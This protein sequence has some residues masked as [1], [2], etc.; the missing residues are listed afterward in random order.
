MF[1]G[2]SGARIPLEAP[3][4]LVLTSRDASILIFWTDP[5]DKYTTPGG[6]LVSEWAYSV[7]VRK[8]GSAPTSPYD[9]VEVVRTTTRN[10]Y[11]VDPYTDSGL[12]NEVTYYYAVYS[13]TTM[14]V[15][16][17]ALVGNETPTDATPEYW[18]SMDIAA[19]GDSEYVYFMSATNTDHHV[20]IAGGRNT[21]SS[22]SVTSKTIAFNSDLVE[23]NLDRDIAHYAMGARYFN[24]YACF[25]CGEDHWYDPDNYVYTFDSELTFQSHSGLA[26]YSR[27][28]VGTARSANHFF[29]FGGEDGNTGDKRNVVCFDEDFTQQDLGTLP[30]SSDGGPWTS[31]AIAGGQ[32]ALLGPGDTSFS[33]PSTNVYSYSDELV[34]TK[35]DF[36]TDM[37]GPMAATVGSYGIFAGASGTMNHDE[38]DAVYAFGNDLTRIS[39]PNSLSPAPS[40]GTRRGQGVDF[41]PYALFVRNNFYDV[42][43]GELTKVQTESSNFPDTIQ[44]MIPNNGVNVLAGVVGK[45]ALL[46]N[47]RS[48]NFSPKVSVF[49][50]I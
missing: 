44:G 32:Y 49:Q 2:G 23:Q 3:T 33:Y 30:D 12:E 10:Q 39:V 41:Y 5:V 43:D 21:N 37:E 26:Y 6:E 50:L 1:S 16:S 35:L 4:N 45:Y 22:N 11:S 46:V 28:Y 24:G 25:A 19:Y 7:V 38:R 47:N 13:Y 17:E 8:Q 14:G 48:D 34:R 15:P 9:G 18:K 42:Y 27:I 20:V 40:F 31:G 29:I 36:P